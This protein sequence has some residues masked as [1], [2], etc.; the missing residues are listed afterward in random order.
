MKDLRIN[1]FSCFGGG[2][3]RHPRFCINQ[4]IKMNAIAIHELVPEGNVTWLKRMAGM[5]AKPVG[6]AWNWGYEI[7][8]AIIIRPL[9]QLYLHGPTAI[10]LWGGHSAP[11]ICSRLTG[12]DAK[13]WD[14]SA[15]MQQE[16]QGV[17]ERHFWSWITLGSSIVYF[18]SLLLLIRY[19]GRRLLTIL[20][21]LV[22]R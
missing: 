9:A 20:P 3:P 18:I 2:L 13:T 6:L 12:I 11:D 15:A 1:I 22:L 17:I 7:S 16:C 8:S 14:S 10:G 19:V 4:Y 5:V 21:G